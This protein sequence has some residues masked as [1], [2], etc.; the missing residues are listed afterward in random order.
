MKAVEVKRLSF[1]YPGRKTPTLKDVS[2]SVSSGE[3]VLICGETGCGK[4]TL[5][6]CLNGLIPFESGGQLQGEIKILGRPG[7]FPPREAF[8]LLATVFQ[9]PTAQLISDTVAG[10][11]AFALENLGLSPEEIQKRVEEALAFVGLL[12]RAQDPPGELSGGQRQ[13]LAIAAALAA[14]PKILLLDE[15]LSQL[16]P[17]GISEVL[18]VLQRLSQRG[19]TILLV[20]HRVREVLPLVDQV[21]YLQDGQVAYQGPPEKWPRPRPK[22]HFLR[23]RLRQKRPVLEIRDLAFAYPGKKPVFAQVNL[24]FYQGERV[25]LLGENGTGKSTFL[26][27]LAGLLRPNKGEIRFCLPQEPGRLPCTLLLQDPDLMLFRPTVREELSF[28]PRMLKLPV[29]ERQERVEQVSRRLGLEGYLEDPP[30]SLSRGERLRTALASLLTGAPQVLLLDEPTTAQDQKHVQKVLTALQAELI[31]FST[32]DHEAA[33]S[34]AH[35]I[36]RFPLRTS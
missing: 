19:Q 31:I 21:L 14:R 26:A 16:D 10:E 27:L 36:I 3:F 29:E 13:R 7:P 18:Q 30:F 5:L 20:E 25:A 33:K 9:N 15:P 4:S 35:R 23:P 1:T 22:L 11:V 32:H 17:K 28:S 12:H 34:F 8:P 24:V 6:S 2:F